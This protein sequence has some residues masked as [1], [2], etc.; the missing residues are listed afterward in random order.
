M[1][2]MLGL[3]LKTN[4]FY[5]YSYFQYWD[6]DDPCQGIR[7]ATTQGQLLKMEHHLSGREHNVPGRAG[8]S[9]YCPA[10]AA[11][12]S[13]LTSPYTFPWKLQGLKCLLGSYET[14]TIWTEVR[15]E[16]QEFFAF[17]LWVLS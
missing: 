9:G 3:S 4:M 1:D 5:F 14:Q 11:Y 13:T 8:G 16:S 2:T 12:V 6:L 17:H 10:T 7:L 15:E